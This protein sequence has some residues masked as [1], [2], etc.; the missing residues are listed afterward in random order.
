ML[1][2]THD[3]TKKYP[4]VHIHRVLKLTET[5]TWKIFNKKNYLLPNV[6]NSIK[7]TKEYLTLINCKV[8]FVNEIAND[9]K[10]FNYN[11][12]CWIDFSLFHVVNKENIESS[13]E[14]LKKISYKKLD[15]L[16][17][18]GCWNDPTYRFQEVSKSVNWRFCGG[19]F[20]G[21][22]EKI[23]EFC[24]LYRNCLESII[25]K[26]NTLLWEVNIWTIMEVEYDWNPTWLSA[27]HDQTILSCIARII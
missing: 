12:F 7:D 20:I 3:L 11:G 27:N 13:Q 18:P 6:R 2:K 25:Q 5:L 15:S 9:Y 16:Y 4:N 23:L 8:E 17:I 24:K 14:V 26:R 22:R 1:P 10:Y 21:N 19:I